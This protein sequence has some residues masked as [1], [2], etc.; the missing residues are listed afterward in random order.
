VTR[1]YATEAQRHLKEDGR[2]NQ[3]LARKTGIDES[4][5]SLF[6]NAKRHPTEENMNKIAHVLGRSDPGLLFGPPCPSNGAR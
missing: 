3:W 5:I 1:T 4:S 2:T 6:L